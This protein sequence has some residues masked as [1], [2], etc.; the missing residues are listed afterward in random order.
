MGLGNTSTNFVSG[1]EAPATPAAPA[2]LVLPARVITS[3]ALPTFSGSMAPTP[4]AAPASR[5]FLLLI[6][7]ALRDWPSSEEAEGRV[8]TKNSALP[9]RQSF[10]CAR[11]RIIARNWASED[12]IGAATTR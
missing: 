2:L 3:A 4:T 11:R 9:E 10:D 1:G 7:S 12:V 6:M 5:N 8:T